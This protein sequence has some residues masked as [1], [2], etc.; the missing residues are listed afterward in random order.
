MDLLSNDADFTRLAFRGANYDIDVASETGE[1]T[2][3]ALGRKP[4]QLACDDQRDLRRRIAHDVRRFGLCKLLILENARNFLGEDILR[5]DRFRNRPGAAKR[6]GSC[7]GSL[8][9]ME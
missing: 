4:A 8:G 1:H 3:K 5:D 9:E 6:F 7:H 2:E